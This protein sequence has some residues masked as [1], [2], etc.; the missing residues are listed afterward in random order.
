MKVFGS[1]SRYYD[2]LYRD[3]DYAGEADYVDSL[4]RRFC[5]SAATVLNL[6]CGSGRH[7]RELVQLGYAVTG[8][9]RSETMLAEARRAASGEKAPEYF[10][11]DLC[12][13]RIP[14]RFDAVLALFHVFSYQST[15]AELRAA[16]AT[17]REHLAPG[18]ICLFDCWYGPAVLTERPSERIKEFGDDLISATR[19]ATPIMHPNDNLV[20]VQYHISI[21]NKHDDRLEELE[22]I[23]RMRYLFRPEV[24]M[25]LEVN[26]LAPVL[27]EEWRTG[28]EPG[29]DTWGVVWGAVHKTD[30]LDGM[31][32]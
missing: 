25:L 22:E 21:R 31:A 17:V 28:C 27:F 1:Y 12:S 7:D 30:C 23:H 32:V 29:F 24:E 14:S 9:D 6:G 13:I 19:T 4:I 15:N 11:G 18:G 5:P 16:F 3:K 8:V 2:L 10:C 20:D 26:G